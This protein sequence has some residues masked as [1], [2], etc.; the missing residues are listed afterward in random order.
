MLMSSFSGGTTSRAFLIQAGVR[1]GAASG[2]ALVAAAISRSLIASNRRQS[3]F[4]AG[5]AVRAR[6]SVDFAFIAICL[7]CRDQPSPRSAPSIDHHHRASL[8]R[9]ERDEALLAIVA[10]RVFALKHAIFPNPRRRGEIDAVLCDIGPVLFRVEFE[11]VQISI[12]HTNI[13]TNTLIVNG[14]PL[15]FALSGL[16]ITRGNRGQSNDDRDF[17]PVRAAA[18]SGQ[19]C[20]PQHFLNFLP[21]PQGQGSF[22][23]GRG[24]AGTRH[25]RR[26]RARRSGRGAARVASSGAAAPRLSRGGRYP[27]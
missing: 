27:A 1:S 10:A 9:A 17:H 19:A 21:E 18:V 7:P 26:R 13:Y 24:R 14:D 23:P 20:R 4:L 12:R 5:P 3:V 16:R 15:G 25:A 11:K 6:R 8:D 22:L 2:S